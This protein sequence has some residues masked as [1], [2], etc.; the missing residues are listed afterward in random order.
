[1]MELNVKKGHVSGSEAL[2]S[3]SFG[4]KVTPKAFH[5][6]ISQL[7]KD[8]NAAFIREL[9]TNAYEAHQMTGNENEPFEVS[10]P[11]S[12]NPS[13]EIR[14]FGPG[15]TPEQIAKVYTM[16]F[17]STKTDSN[18]MGGCFGLGSKSPFAYDIDVQ[19]GVISWVDG[20]K[21]CYAVFK[22]EEGYPKMDL[23]HK[24]PST[25]RS[26]VKISIP[27]KRHDFGII[28][29]KARN[30]YQW[31]STTPKLVSGGRPF[32][33]AKASSFGNSY[34]QYLEVHGC[35]AKMGNILYKIDDNLC[36]LHGLGRY[37][38]VVEFPIG[39]LTPEPSREGLSYDKIT[40]RNIEEAFMP[41]K[42]EM[43]QVIQKEIDA[44][45]DYYEAC[46]KGIRAISNS[47]VGL[48]EL[49][50]GGEK[51]TNRYGKVMNAELFYMNYNLKFSSHGVDNSVS[52]S[53]HA[54][55]INID[56]KCAW[57]EIIKQNVLSGKF[58]R[59]AP[60]FICN[61]A[62]SNHAVATLVSEVKI[63]PARVISVSSLPYTPKPKAPRKTPT[64]KHMT[65]VLT[66]QCSRTLQ[67]SW[68]D[69]EVDLAKDKGMYV[70]YYKNKIL[71]P[72]LAKPGENLEVEPFEL[73][74]FLDAVGY[75]GVVYGIKK[76]TVD[77]VKTNPNWQNLLDVKKDTL[78]NKL[79]ALNFASIKS[80]EKTIKDMKYRDSCL[81]ALL[82]ML[83]SGKITTTNTEVIALTAIYKDVK[84]LSHTNVD[85]MIHTVY[86]LYGENIAPSG[87]VVA[88]VALDKASKDIEDKFPLIK[89]LRSYQVDVSVA[90]ELV[91]YIE[92]K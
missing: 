86:K 30:I 10:L 31:F 13:F 14:D 48:T 9:S 59:S 91:S 80:A 27:I 36:N 77:K 67:D 76:D 28:E 6:M 26:G 58:N 40:K 92:G 88:N 61:T 8:P 37:P 15:L 71:T 23:L 53:E 90:K 17:E 89:V 70:V 46:W 18:D 60:L 69:S 21:Y 50:Y 56:K 87:K 74:A 5:L 43:I 83:E 73:T 64:N 45:Q 16:L 1:M 75:K 84:K 85:S 57:K 7:Y 42:A 62:Y 25:E 2:E 39:K 32:E 35:H 82:D 68:T 79:K 49:T 33:K 19:F 47:P 3:Y 24:E 11:H 44:C 12:L 52:P 29:S 20:I 72:N 54:V 65:K 78:Y 66:W 38:L 63:N 81:V 55:F 22:D 34:S 41:I 51:L 4:F